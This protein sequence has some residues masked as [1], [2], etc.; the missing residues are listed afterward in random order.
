MI[1]D[2][3]IYL[4]S[5]AVL[6]EIFL[7][8]LSKGIQKW[9]KKAIILHDQVKGPV[10]QTWFQTKRISSHLSEE[11]ILNL[12][13]SAK[14]LGLFKLNPDLCLNYDKLENHFQKIQFF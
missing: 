3:I 12:P 10:S 2:F 13:M 7:R 9:K 1:A 14:D 11:M 5:K 8:D 6:D 4:A